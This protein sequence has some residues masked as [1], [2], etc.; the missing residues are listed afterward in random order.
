MNVTF[1]AGI[2]W[3]Y[4]LTKIF[5]LIVIKC[6]YLKGAHRVAQKVG[7]SLCKYPQK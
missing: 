2:F 6:Y 1:V 5:Q 4:N 3:G 7:K